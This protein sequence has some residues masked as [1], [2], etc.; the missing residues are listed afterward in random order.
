MDIDFLCTNIGGCGFFLVTFSWQK[1]AQ[2]SILSHSSSS[3]S[4]SLISQIHQKG[5]CFCIITMI[6]VFCY[7]NHRPTIKMKLV[8]RLR[9]LITILLLLLRVENR[10]R[11]DSFVALL[12]KFPVVRTQNP[13]DNHQYILKFFYGNIWRRLG[14]RRGCS[15]FGSAADF[16]ICR[17]WWERSVQKAMN[18]TFSLRFC[19]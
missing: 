8:S 13:I 5:D 7:K 19:Y 17:W 6:L 11:I 4:W 15:S 18:C 10:I 9:H 14:F 1:P 16:M 2:D 3:Y 12:M